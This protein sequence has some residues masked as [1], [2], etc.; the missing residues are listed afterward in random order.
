MT[1]R[2]ALEQS[3]NIFK[4]FSDRQRWEFSN[5]LFHLDFITAR[6]D[7]REVIA[8]VGCGIGLLALALKILGYQV[9]GYDKYV[10]IG[11]DFYNKED[12]LVLNDI[13]RKHGLEIV[14]ADILVDSLA[15]EPFGGVISIATLE[16]QAFPRLFLEKMVT[17]LKADGWIYIVT[18]NIATFLNRLRFLAGRSPLS[19]IGEFFHQAKNFSG[20][21]REYTLQELIFMFGGLDLFVEEAKNVGLLKSRP[22]LNRK[23]FRKIFLIVGNFL[24]GTKDTI[25]IFARRKKTLCVE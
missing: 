11:D 18:P 15:E 8:D 10:F 9:K 6:A 12:S 2:E 23:F 24:P 19:N 4:P 7:K 13:W 17:L 16:H 1:N 3:Y 22:K 14:P 21:W 20:H 25:L 5:N